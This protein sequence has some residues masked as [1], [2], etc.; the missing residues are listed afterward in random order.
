MPLA[1]ADC[2]LDAVAPSA[3]A[4][5]WLGLA[6]DWPGVAAAWAGAAR[7]QVPAAELG[8]LDSPGAALQR[9]VAVVSVDAGLRPA[10]AAERDAVPQLAAAAELGAAL[11]LGAAPA[12]VA[13][14]Q[15]AAAVKPAAAA[16]KPARA[17]RNAAVGGQHCR[18]RMTKRSVL[19]P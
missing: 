4:A 5:G 14:K 1:A 19:Q 12:G 16:V 11:E 17:A 18:A 13:V 2:S 15:A 6:A 8:V 7:R 3:G 10:R 9:G